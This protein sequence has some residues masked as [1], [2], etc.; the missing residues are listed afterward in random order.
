MATNAMA[1]L[2]DVYVW[3]TADAGK[4]NLAL[5][6]S[7]FDNLSGDRHFGPTVVYAFHLSSRPGFGMA[8]TESKIICK[9]ASDTDGE[10][11]V[12][13]PNG[14]TVDYVKGDFSTATGKA[15]PSGKF[16]VFAGKRSD[17]FFFN[18]GGFVAAVTGAVT[19]CGGTCPPPAGTDAAKCVQIAGADAALLRG[20]IATKPAANNP[21]TLCD[22]AAD[23][24]CFKSANVM[25][26]VVEVDK[27][28]VL[29]GEDKLVSVWASTHAGS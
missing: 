5:T 22:D 16:R 13:D 14:K 10:C 6:V 25:A 17:P 20:A 15:A 12:V 11:F 3:M 28:L 4:L 19:K 7:P 8:G 18:L 2:D 24:D 23:I 9:F 27:T 1:D 29:E 21:A 26:I